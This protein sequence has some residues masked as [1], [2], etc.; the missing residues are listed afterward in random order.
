MDKTKFYHFKYKGKKILLGY[1][2]YKNFS[3]YAIG[4][5]TYIIVCI[6]NS[7]NKRVKSKLLHRAIKGR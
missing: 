5:K 2:N 3:W 4:K 6:N 1:C 7:Y